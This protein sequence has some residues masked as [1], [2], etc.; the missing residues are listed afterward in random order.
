MAPI[1]VAIVGLSASAKTAWASRAHLPYLLSARGRERFEIV[2]LLNSSVDAAKAAI[3]AY[4]LPAT[5]KAYG[6]PDALAADADVDLVVVNTR[7]DV[8]HAVI[9]PSVAAGKAAFVEWPLAQDAAHARDLADL[10]REKGV[11]AK[12]AVG[13]QGRL[14]PVAKAVRAA[15][16]A[17]RIGKLLSVEVRA[18]GGTNDRDAVPNTLSYFLDRD[19]GGHIY[20]IGAAHLIDLVQSVVGEVESPQAQFTLQ[21][22]TVTIKDAATGAAIGTAPSNV[23]DLIL[24]SGTLAPSAIVAPHAASL[25]YRYRRG[26]QFPG[27]PA[28]TWTLAGETGEIRVTSEKSATISVINDFPPTVELYDFATGAVELISWQWLPWQEELPIFARGI[29]AIYEAISEGKGGQ[30]TFEDAL[31]RHEQLEGLLAPW[32]A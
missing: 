21:R 13:L 10:A 30:V 12:S 27:D 24:I 15:L 9:R 5:T 29:G 11:L 18:F 25:H 4:E 17:G 6:D 7:V 31:K 14:S 22:P 16:D 19:V 32:K 26:Q 20:S 1:R 2:A 3:A 8:H 23:P 28:L